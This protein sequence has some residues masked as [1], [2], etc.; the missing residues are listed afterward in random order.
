MT[1]FRACTK[2]SELLPAIAL[3][4]RWQAALER[5]DEDEAIACL[6][7]DIEYVVS[8]LLPGTSVRAVGLDEV[9]REVFREGAK[10]YAA[11]SGTEEL[12]GGEVCAARSTLSLTQTPHSLARSLP[13]QELRWGEINGTAHVNTV[14]REFVYRQFDVSALRHNFV[15][16]KQEFHIAID[17]EPPPAT[18]AAPDGLDAERPVA[19]VHA[20][21]RISK[22]L[23]VE[24]SITAGPA[25]PMGHT[26]AGAPLSSPRSPRKNF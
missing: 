23:L 6:D 24:E 9:R 4:S 14:V 10:L 17:D 2:R 19:R 1:L 5:G 12:S 8:G 7:P 20:R 22:M 18:G 13:V 25:P 11:V 15:R 26:S 21:M 3:V 16:A